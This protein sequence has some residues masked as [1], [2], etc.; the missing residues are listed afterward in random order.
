MKGSKKQL[1]QIKKVNSNDLI[2][3]YKGKTADA[4]FDKFDNALN[5]MNKTKNGEMRLANVKNNQRKFK[6]YIGKIKKRTDVD[7][8]S[9]NTLCIILKCFTKQEKRLLNFMMIIF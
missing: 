4:K 8:K 6:S 5:I 7:Q 2:N 3:R 9:K 1:I